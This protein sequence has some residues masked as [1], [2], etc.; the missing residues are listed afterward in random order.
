MTPK[1]TPA[2][3]Q[4]EQFVTTVQEIMRNGCGISFKIHAVFN[5]CIE[6]VL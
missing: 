4:G 6:S 5:I 1:S 3:S 2:E